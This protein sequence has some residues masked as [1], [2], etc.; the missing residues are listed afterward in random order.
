MN[1]S[2]GPGRGLAPDTGREV[3]PGRAAACG[4]RA[5]TRRPAEPGAQHAAPALPPVVHTPFGLP[6]RWAAIVSARQ[7]AP[8]APLLSGSQVQERTDPSARVLSASSSLLSPELLA[9]SPSRPEATAQ[10]GEG[11]QR[12]GTSGYRANT[13]LFHP[14]V[15]SEVERSGRFKKH[16]ESPY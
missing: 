12:E 11:Q 6:S 10:T 13:G 7:Q 16:L 2:Q 8:L 5:G 1:W 4:R 3:G 15:M 9:H 14:Q